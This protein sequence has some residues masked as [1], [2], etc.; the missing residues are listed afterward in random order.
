VAIPTRVLLV[1]ITLRLLLPPGICIC[2]LSSPAAYLLSRALG[3]EPPAPE[4]D[5]HDDHHSG[6]P[7]SYLSLGMGVQPAAPGLD[8]DPALPAPVVEL[9]AGD[10]PATVARLPAHSHFLAAA[11]PLYVCH[12]A[13]LF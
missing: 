8:A 7:S 3:G 11:P 9:P 5:H 13:L 6:C 2:N 10:T 12:C 1:L 4:P